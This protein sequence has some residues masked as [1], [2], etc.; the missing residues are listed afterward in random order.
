MENN[1][2]S[3]NPFGN[4]QS[5]SGYESTPTQHQQSY[6]DGGFDNRIQQSIP[7]DPAALVIGIISIVFFF[8]SC[9]LYGIGAPLSLIGGIIGLVIANKGVRAY[10]SDPRSYS[11]SSYKSVNAGKIINIITIA[12]SGITTL[13]IILF[14]AII[15]LSLSELADGDFSN[16]GQE[17]EYE[18][19]ETIED[20]WYYYEE[21]I[22]TL[23][24]KV[25]SLNTEGIIE[26]EELIEEEN[27]QDQ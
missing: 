26:I 22:D 23:D 27:E 9:C 13:I 2:D 21:D 5:S 3:Q 18:K 4:Q 17:Y 11:Q 16:F 12:I 25:D 7:G 10:K 8:I 19:E 20:D 6:S 15:G 14:V 24:Q 1:N